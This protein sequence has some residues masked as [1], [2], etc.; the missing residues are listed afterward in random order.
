MTEVYT[1]R[2][3]TPSE[4]EIAS[5]YLKSGMDLERAVSASGITGSAGSFQANGHE[6]LS[7]QWLVNTLSNLKNLKNALSK[8]QDILVIT[9]AGAS[10]ESG[11]KTF[12]GEEGWYQNKRAEE[13]ATLAAFN[14]D[15][16]KIWGWY[17]KRRQALV[18]AEP[19]AGHKAI[20]SWE[21]HGKHVMIITQNVDDLHE[22]A[23]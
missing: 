19:N 15:P 16:A 20:S 3:L 11:L 7:D 2:V 10:A 21:H 5:V 14:N 1:H 18:A 12:R 6:I 4:L 23:G 22:R 17:D 8:A 9:G 13:L